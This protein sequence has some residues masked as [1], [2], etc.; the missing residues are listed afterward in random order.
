M[1]AQS[2][3]NELASENYFKKKHFKMLT[4]FDSD[5]FAHSQYIDENEFL[6][7][8]LNDYFSVPAPLSNGTEPAYEPAA[9]SS[10]N[11]SPNAQQQQQQQQKTLKSVNLKT[12]K[13]FQKSYF[14]ESICGE[15]IKVPHWRLKEKV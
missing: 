14:N 8:H 6:A 5:E 9:D 4:S 13:L 7:D 11:S 3:Y 2:Y 12:V 10:T 1:C 15:L